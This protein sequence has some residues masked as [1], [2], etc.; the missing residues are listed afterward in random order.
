MGFMTEQAARLL[1]PGINTIDEVLQEVW[2][3]FNSDGPIVATSPMVVYQQNGQ[4]PI[5]T[6]VQPYPDMT[7]PP[8]VTTITQGGPLPTVPPFAPAPTIPGVPPVSFPSLPALPPLPP[9]PG[10]PPYP[11][12]LPIIPP[13]PSVP[14][15]PPTSP[16]T[17]PSPP[18]PPTS[19]GGGGGFSAVVL[20]QVGG[21]NYN[22]AIYSSTPVRPDIP[23][24]LCRAANLNPAGIPLPVGLE[25]PCVQVGD[26]FVIY[27]PFFVS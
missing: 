20:G 16:P 27:P 19:G 2:A 1:K 25:L 9:Q 17:S 8:G 4:T 24:Q 18:V 26:T 3:V 12:P 7:S 14:G 10:M 11:P 6:V 23:I 15:V 13:P 5:T 22:C 21:N